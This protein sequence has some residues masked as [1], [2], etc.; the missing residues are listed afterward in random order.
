M[1]NQAMAVF[2]AMN[3]VVLYLVWHYGIRRYIIDRFRVRMFALRDRLFRIVADSD[4]V[5]FDSDVNRHLS[6]VINAHLHYADSMTFLQLWVFKI[7][8]SEELKNAPSPFEDL[9][10]AIDEL[11]E[12]ER[13]QIN[14]IFFEVGWEGVVCMSFLNPI[15]LVGLV[16]AILTI[17]IGVFCKWTYARVHS[18]LS[19]KNEFE[20]T[21]SAHVD[22]LLEI[23]PLRRA[24]RSLENS[25]DQRLASGLRRGSGGL[26]AV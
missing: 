11:P 15:L 1:T 12:K 16:V 7:R 2:V 26:S 13:E 14:K 20:R 22:S 19:A 24:A 8:H 18:A 5:D 9:R 25:I 21:Q 4:T 6:D 3:A 10:H 23:K 17:A